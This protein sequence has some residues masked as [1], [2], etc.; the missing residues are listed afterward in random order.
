MSRTVQLD[1]LRARLRRVADLGPDSTSGRYP[2]ADCDRELN[3]AWQL[4]REMMSENGHQLYL[5]QTTPA[6]FTV[7]PVNSN[8]PWGSIPWPADAIAVYAIHVVI[9]AQELRKLY[10]VDLDQAMDF[11]DYFGQ[12]NGPPEAFHVYNVGVEAGAAVTAGTIGILPAPNLAYS[13]TIWY[14]PS[15]VDRTGTQVFDG[16]A[17][18][19][20]WV[21]WTAAVKF[22]SGDNDR[23]A[24]YQIAVSERAKFE[25]LIKKRANN[26]QRVGGQGKRDV[27][28]EQKMTRARGY[29]RWP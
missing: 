26:I 28:S 14:L 24:A 20:E 8:T 27:R 25:E 21:L 23:Q 19:E 16:I 10:P 22:L 5:K 4:M 29:W 3:A 13:Y 6:T 18:F 1:V 11:T 7:G 2:N 9:S 15:W 17:G 12:K